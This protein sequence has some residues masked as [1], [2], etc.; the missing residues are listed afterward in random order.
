MRE[1][2]AELKDG[3]YMV[4][5]AWHSHCRAPPMV[6]ELEHLDE[7]GEMVQIL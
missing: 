6:D 7:V 2:I 5:V 4:L 3:A 1:L